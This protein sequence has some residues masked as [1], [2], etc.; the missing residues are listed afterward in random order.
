[1][2]VQLLSHNHPD[3]I[4][5]PLKLKVKLHRNLLSKRAAGSSYLLF[6]FSFPPS[7][8][9][10]LLPFLSPSFS[11]SHAVNPPGGECLETM[12]QSL[13]KERGSRLPPPPLSGG[14]G[15]CTALS[16]Q[17]QDP[18]TTVRLPAA[19]SSND[20][21][22]PLKQSQGHTGTERPA[23]TRVLMGTE[24]GKNLNFCVFQKG[25]EGYPSISHLQ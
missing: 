24:E 15:R 14:I 3:L 16:R 4:K 12:H 5:S 22:L 23:K 17:Q 6:L 7:L 25:I 18:R 2:E 13:H 21:P 8:A 20:R 19:K 10:H 11:A 9:A 1:M